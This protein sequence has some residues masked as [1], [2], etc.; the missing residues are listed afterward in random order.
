M[1]FKFFFTL[2]IIFVLYLNFSQLSTVPSEI[3]FILSHL[4]LSYYDKMVH[5]MGQEY[6]YIDFVLRNT[7]KYSTIVTPPPRPPWNN[8]GSDTYLK[9]YFW[10]R[11]L[12]RGHLA[13]NQLPKD[14]DYALLVW[15]SDE[16]SP[17][18]Q[19]DWPMI[20]IKKY[21]VKILQEHNPKLGLIYL[22][23]D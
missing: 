21:K 8:L 20:D 18:A 6:L 16:G 7:P 13:D 22:K 9:Y 5:N 2:L 11:K 19:L 3:K 23:N 14:A 12:L 4:N 15:Y 10:P 1:S 17:S